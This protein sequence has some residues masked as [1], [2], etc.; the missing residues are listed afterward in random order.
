MLYNT[1]LHMSELLLMNIKL[2]NN[3]KLDHWEMNIM[4]FSPQQGIIS[5]LVFFFCSGGQGNLPT[6]TPDVIELEHK[7]RGRDGVVKGEAG[8]AHGVPE[9]PLDQPAPEELLQQGTG[10][11]SKTGQTGLATSPP[12]QI[13]TP[14]Q[15][16]H[17]LTGV[18]PGGG[19]ENQ[20]ART[21]QDHPSQKS[22]SQKSGSARS[23]HTQ[24]QQQQHAV[25]PKM[26]VQLAIL[27]NQ[28][29]NILK[30]GREESQASTS[31]SERERQRQGKG[32]TS[33]D[34]GVQRAGA[35]GQ[36][37]GPI[38]VDEGGYE[39]GT[40]GPLAD[41][42]ELNGGMHPEHDV[43]QERRSSDDGV[44]VNGTLVLETVPG[45]GA[46]DQP[47]RI[48]DDDDNKVQD[49]PKI[50][51]PDGEQESGRHVMLGS[52]IEYVP[53]NGSVAFGTFEERSQT[54]MY[55]E[56]VATSIYVDENATRA[57]PYTLASQF[58]VSMAS[59]EE[60]SEG[61]Q[62]WE[63]AVTR[64][65]PSMQSPARDPD[66]RRS[67]HI[68]DDDKPSASSSS[69]PRRHSVPKF[70]LGKENQD[71]KEKDDAEDKDKEDSDEKTQTQSVGE[72]YERSGTLK[73]R[74]KKK[75]RGGGGGK[76][77]SPSSPMKVLAFHDP[78]GGSPIHERMLPAPHHQDRGAEG[79]SAL[80][81]V[82]IPRS[83]SGG[84]M[85]D[86]RP[87]SAGSHHSL[88]AEMLGKRLSQQDLSKLS[89]QHQQD[90]D[91]LSLNHSRD[92]SHH[93]HI[94]DNSSHSH[95]HSRESHNSRKDG[96]SR[97]HSKTSE[98]DAKLSEKEGVEPEDHGEK[99]VEFHVEGEKDGALLKGA[100]SN[101]ASDSETTYGPR[102]S[103]IKLEERGMADGESPR[104][105]L[106]DEEGTEI[107]EDS[108]VGPGRAGPSLAH[109]ERIAQSIE[110]LAESLTR[111]GIQNNPGNVSN[112]NEKPVPLQ[113]AHSTTWPSLH[114]HTRSGNTSPQHN[115]TP[116]AGEKTN[117]A[118]INSN[119]QDQEGQ[120][121]ELDADRDSLAESMS[122]GSGK[123]GGSA[124]ERELQSLFVSSTQPRVEDNLLRASFDMTRLSEQLHQ[125]R[126]T[127][128]DVLRMPRPPTNPAPHKAARATAARSVWASF[129]ISFKLQ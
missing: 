122:R 65:L 70:L 87:S 75:A 1:F 48:E 58:N 82:G 118:K 3:D 98:N 57:A 100:N 124:S 125:H 62:K 91:Q 55:G 85:R 73:R 110:R 49:M 23:S 52:A 113:M 12:M 26:N 104:Q 117:T 35:P 109:Q 90:A 127:S 6:A 37:N 5:E 27:D 9:K 78:T 8:G 41:I 36:S 107:P 59:S 51:M 116:P 95:S 11:V 19:A 43:L 94:K 79:G 7:S 31:L 38:A 22:Q 121:L 10:G 14:P 115:R 66:K 93:S 45:E 47:I 4:F 96:L 128:P 42:V 24:Q 108:S 50:S 53:R 92:H 17:S 89:Q 29:R 71:E 28:L 119:G 77:S 72:D 34:G 64:P 15:S 67:W 86:F 103:E 126:P 13:G 44:N 16:Q 111:S 101:V 80:A 68:G 102:N 83:N 30:S 18:A 129:C 120:L 33:G 60:D 63:V 123:L 99:V 76:L 81:Y 2:G 40:E 25:D 20:G 114:Q 112:T 21:L 69:E 106:A 56:Y 54:N 84:F 32:E 46:V 88:R 97:Q 61:E 105:V 74:K 39:A